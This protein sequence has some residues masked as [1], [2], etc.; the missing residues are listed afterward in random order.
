L[1]TEWK[2]T[3]R[4][5]ARAVALAFREKEGDEGEFFAH[6]FERLQSAAGKQ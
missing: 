2:D 1:G 5:R 3:I 6:L 4:M